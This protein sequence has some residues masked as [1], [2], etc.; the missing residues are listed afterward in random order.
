MEL[1]ALG[2]TFQ[3]SQ[4]EERTVVTTHDVVDELRGPSK[5][6]LEA[7]P[8]ALSVA[9]LMDGGPATVFG[10][11]GVGRSRGVRSRG[12]GGRLMIPVDQPVGMTLPRAVSR[13]SQRTPFSF[14]G[15]G[16]LR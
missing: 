8:E 10:P 11:E 15:R 5:S 4:A 1:A 7:A 12:A 2:L 3:G 16:A 13:T 6:L 9:L 14:T